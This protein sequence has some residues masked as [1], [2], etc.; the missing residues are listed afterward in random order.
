MPH[1]LPWGIYGNTVCITNLQ[2]ILGLKLYN[3]FEKEYYRMTH[4]D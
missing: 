1:N 4:T 2:L 3:T